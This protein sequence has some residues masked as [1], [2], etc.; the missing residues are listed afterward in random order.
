VL[1]IGTDARDRIEGLL[2]QWLVK[3]FLHELGVAKDGGE[4]SPQLM[5]HW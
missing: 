4:R 2:A 5:A 3:A 1:A